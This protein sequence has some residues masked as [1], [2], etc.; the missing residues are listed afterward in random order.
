M[1]ETSQWPLTED[2]IRYITPGFMLHLLGNSRLSRA[3]YPTAVGYYPSATGHQM[4]RKEHD[5]NLLIYCTEGQGSVKTSHFSG[6]IKPGD[7]LLLPKGQSHEYSADR[8]DPWTIYWF[9]FDGLEADALIKGL[10]YEPDQPVVHI[11]QQPMLLGD[12]KRL[13]GLRKSGY[14][15]AVFTYAASITRQILCQ[16]ALNVRNR[17]AISR[18]NF[19]L[20]EI[21]G[22]MMDHIETDLNLETLANCARLSKYHFANKY[23]QLTGYPP[24]KHFIH[25]KMEHACYLLDNTLDSISRIAGRLGYDDPLYFSRIF[26]KTVGTSPSSYRLQRT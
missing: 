13:L 22:L 9:H 11:G 3:C 8:R 25:M 18:H 23:K 6:V 26:K 16:L 2:A 10:D 15:Y 12:L 20:D 4:T 7:L 19:N 1:S 24:I 5:E 17:T 14:Q 21:Q